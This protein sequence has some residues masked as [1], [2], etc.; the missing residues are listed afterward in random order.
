[1]HLDHGAAIEL[2]DSADA[3]MASAAATG[4]EGMS[5]EATTCT[6]ASSSSACNA[7]KVPVTPVSVDFSAPSSAHLLVPAHLLERRHGGAQSAPANTAQPGSQLKLKSSP[8]YSK[9]ELLKCHLM[10][11]KAGGKIFTVKHVKK[12]CK[13]SAKASTAR[14]LKNAP[15]SVPCPRYVLFWFCC[16]FSLAL[17]ALGQFQD[18]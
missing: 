10:P 3:P 9:K 18:L 1:M 16:F 5:V 8:M 12:L 13:P 14:G 6:S 2:W 11:A 17:L 4:G 15:S 7:G